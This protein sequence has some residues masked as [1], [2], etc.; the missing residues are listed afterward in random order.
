M[1]NIG[2]K[3]RI[4]QVDNKFLQLNPLTAQ[5]YQEEL[6]SESASVKESDA[7]AQATLARIEK[8]RY[9]AI[10]SGYLISRKFHKEAEFKELDIPLKEGLRKLKLH[11]VIAEGSLRRE[12]LAQDGK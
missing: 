6:P 11:E 1:K 2:R 10:K 12:K 7:A 8:I 9:D 5:H 3:L 4:D